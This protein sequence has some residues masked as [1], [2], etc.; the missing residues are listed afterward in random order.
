MIEY[1][2]R[3]VEIAASYGVKLCHENEKGI[4]GDTAE[5]VADLMES[6]NGLRFVYD[7]ANFLQVGETP[8]RTLERFCDRCDYFHIKD[9][10]L[11]SGE[12]VP[13][14][15]GDGQIGALLKR[16][17]HRDTILTVEPH[18]HIFGAYADIDGEEMKHRFHFQSNGEAF[19]M[20]VASLRRL[21][22][23][24]GC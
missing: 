20:A 21:M 14:G 19:D 2:Q 16:I 1:L 9:V 17:A 5:R 11:E 7:P 4:Y 10:V 23:E 12:L 13:A 24:T 8:D 15:Y 3:M 18:L 22:Q 6:V